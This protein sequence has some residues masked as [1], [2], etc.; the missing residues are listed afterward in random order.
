M[1]IR[2]ATSKETERAKTIYAGK[3]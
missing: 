1:M 2:F 3:L